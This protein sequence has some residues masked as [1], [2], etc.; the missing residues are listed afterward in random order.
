MIGSDNGLSPGRIL[1]KSRC[2]IADETLADIMYDSYNIYHQ[3]PGA[4]GILL[5]DVCPNLGFS[6]A[7][8]SN[9]YDAVLHSSDISGWLTDTPISE[10]TEQVTPYAWLKCATDSRR[11]DPHATSL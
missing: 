1:F 5:G 2:G 9:S 3:L 7:S 10:A 6:H 11:H 8:M 4:T